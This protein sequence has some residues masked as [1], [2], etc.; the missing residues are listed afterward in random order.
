LRTKKRRRR[1]GKKKRKRRKEKEEN[2]RMVQSVPMRKEKEAI[3]SRKTNAS[4][5]LVEKETE[6]EKC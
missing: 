3:Q 6:D 5:E 4:K 2:W 1:R